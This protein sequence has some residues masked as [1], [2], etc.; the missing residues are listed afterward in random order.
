MWVPAARLLPLRKS[1]SVGGSLLLIAIGAILYWA[2]TYQV[3]GVSLHMVGLILM[4]IGG[5][6]VVLGLIGT[7]T[8]RHLP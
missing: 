2:V 1:M 3:R 7:A 4:I 5:I 8:T 6:G